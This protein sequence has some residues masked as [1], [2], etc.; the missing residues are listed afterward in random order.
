MLRHGEASM[1][2]AIVE[3]ATMH[4]VVA[5]IF[6]HNEVFYDPERTHVAHIPLDCPNF[7]TRLGRALFALNVASVAAEAPEFDRLYGADQIGC[8]EFNP[9]YHAAV[10]DAGSAWREYRAVMHMLK[11]CRMAYDEPLFQ[12]LQDISGWL[13]HSII[14]AMPEYQTASVY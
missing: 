4:I 6:A 12:E 8:Y 7:E 13:A 1:S 5:A 3:V 10:L 11:Q 9:Q 14:A 2:C